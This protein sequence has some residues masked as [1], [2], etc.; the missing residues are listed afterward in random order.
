[1]IPVL[2]GK[3]GYNSNVLNLPL[4]PLMYY[5]R[6]NIFNPDL[7]EVSLGARM[8]GLCYTIIVICIAN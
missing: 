3:W 4:L 1:M 8:R 2:W 5:Y 7:P 6:L